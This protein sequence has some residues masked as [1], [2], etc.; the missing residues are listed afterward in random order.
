VGFDGLAAEIAN[1]TG[2][3]LGPLTYL[4]GGARALLTWRGV[5]FRVTVDDDAHSFTGWFVA[6]GNV[7]QYG[8]GL[9]ITPNAMADDGRM[10]VVMMGE[11]HAGVA[12][13]TFLKAFAGTHLGHPSITE[14]RGQRVVID[15]NVPLNVYADGE[16]IG[17]L[18]ATI[19]VDPAAV[20]VL[21]PESSP[22]LR[23]LER[24]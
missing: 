17:P 23:V 15:A 10:D 20:S 22:V 11:A 8:G 12:V 14:T 2:I 9:R 4:Y 3:N 24:Q 16:L 7:G 5:T 19:D 13:S 21:V 1:A 6:V 18:P